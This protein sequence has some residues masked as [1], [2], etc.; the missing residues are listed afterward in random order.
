M[1]AV[2]REKLLTAAGQI[3]KIGFSVVLTVLAACTNRNGV[4]LLACLGELAC[5][6]TVCGCLVS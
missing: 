5:I 6:L 3:Y 2:K 1:I 4:L